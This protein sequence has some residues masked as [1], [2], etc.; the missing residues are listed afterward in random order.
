MKLSADKHAAAV[1][2]FQNGQLQQAIRLFDEL[3]H[4][5]E[6]S[7]LW[8]DW[9]TAQAAN[10]NVTEAITGLLRALE[11]NPQNHPAKADLAILLLSLGEASRAAALIDEC[12]PFL[13]GQ[14]QQLLRTAKASI[15]QKE[16]C[17]SSSS[18]LVIDDVFP[19][20]TDNASEP[21]LL[22]IVRALRDLGHEVTLVVRDA[23]NRAQWAAILRKLDIRLYSGDSERL[24]ALGIKIGDPTWSFAEVLANTKFAFAI[25]TQSFTRGISIPEHYLNDIRR[26]SPQTRIAILSEELYGARTSE[27]ART[28][29][30]L[31]HHETAA[32][33]T[34]REQEALQRADLAI[35]SHQR[36]QQSLSERITGLP[37]AIVT[38]VAAEL[39]EALAWA[40][41]LTPKPAAQESFS[42]TL[43]DAIYSQLLQQTSGD[44]RVYS[45]LDFYVQ[46]AEQLLRHDKASLARDQLRHVFGWLGDSI[47]LAPALAQPLTLLSRCYRQMGEGA[48]ALRCAEEA[49]RCFTDRPG[50]R[51]PVSRSTSKSKNQPL[52]SLIVPSYNRLPILKK[53]LAA[54]EVQTISPESFEV[55]VID[56]GSSDGTEELMRQYQPPFRLQYLRQNNSGTGTAR[57]NGVS[58]ATGEYLLLMNDDTICDVN[59]IEE[60]LLAQRFYA[61]ERWAVLGN[62]EYPAEARKRALTH[63]FRVNPFMFPQVEM[64]NGCA[65]GYSHFITCNLSIKR[66]A[67]LNV[68]SFDGTY[69]L[70]EDTEMGIK[71]FESGYSVVYHS[72]AHAWHDHLPYAVRNLVRRARIYGADYFYMFRNHPRVMRE[73]AMPVKLDGMDERNALRIRAY[74]EEHRKDVQAAVAALERWDNVDFEPILADRESSEHVLSL[75]HQSVPAVHW[76]YLLERML[77]VMAKE[78]AMPDLCAHNQLPLAAALGK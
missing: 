60:H 54:L 59:L 61:S 53:C 69:M 24:A 1:E 48:M 30:E 78:L 15:A 68:G 10:G 23:A 8:N 52:I 66:D 42:M 14:Q 21:R 67:V 38:T 72:A 62:F 76:F 58:H 11:L 74:V 7:D 27:K 2:A 71:L 19:R 50:A 63:F 75:F 34:Q 20:R 12:L 51:E 45:R 18:I 13:A 28:T 43:V 37:I 70:S 55:I 31:K 64:E 77:E 41:R 49:R 5:Q 47:K 17:L 56:D 32:D 73:W 65:Y 3:L 57:R 40:S 35:V 9:A 26:Q 46:L 33:F 6:S 25:L 29:G 44:Q 36:E 4:A 39:T 16:S 22:Q